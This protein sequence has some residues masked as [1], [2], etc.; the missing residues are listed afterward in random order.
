M[1]MYMYM[2]TYIHVYICTYMYVYIYIYI[3]MY[4][5]M[6]TYLYQQQNPFFIRNQTI[7]IGIWANHTSFFDQPYIENHF[8]CW[9]IGIP[10]TKMGGLFMGYVEKTIFHD[11]SIYIYKYLHTYTYVYVFFS[12]DDCKWVVT[13]TPNSIWEAI[14]N[15]ST[16]FSDKVHK[17]SWYEKMQVQN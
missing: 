6:Y 1:Y 15:H 8:G 16:L 10:P 5:F 17:R 12:W 14:T 4:L 3:Y 2:Y 9:R 11:M 7:W 13:F